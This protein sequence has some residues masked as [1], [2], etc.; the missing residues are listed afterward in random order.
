MKKLERDVKL[1]Q[2]K[3]KKDGYKLEIL[4]LRRRRNVSSHNLFSTTAY[5][6][7]PKTLPYKNLDTLNFAAVG[8]SL[9][10]AEIVLLGSVFLL[11]D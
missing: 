5:F 4:D 9:F 11:A 10:S 6:R 7:P 1:N 8:V 2:K 3:K